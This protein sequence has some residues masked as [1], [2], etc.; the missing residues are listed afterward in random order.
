[1]HARS[2][3][4]KYPRQ[5]RV[6]RTFLISGTDLYEVLVPVLRTLHWNPCEMSGHLTIWKFKKIFYLIFTIPLWLTEF[7]GHIFLWRIVHALKCGIFNNFPTTQ[8]GSLFLK[9]AHIWATQFH[10][11]L[12]LGKCIEFVDVEQKNEG[13]NGVRPQP[14]C[15]CQ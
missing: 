13:K 12:R 15:P 4:W 14:H 7:D 6:T 11:R 9:C 10:I 2:L 1:M 5:H 8:F 3:S